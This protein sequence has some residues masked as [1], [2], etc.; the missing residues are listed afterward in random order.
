MG[1]AGQERRYDIDWLRVLAM[2]MIFS[3]TA[4]GS[5]IVTAGM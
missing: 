1:M 2:L 4:H 3:S 5:S